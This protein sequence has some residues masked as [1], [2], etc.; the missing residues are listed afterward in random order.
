MGEML[1]TVSVNPMSTV[2][3]SHQA[4][5]RDIFARYL[6]YGRNAHVTRWAR[7]NHAVRFW[8]GQSAVKRVPL[9][10]LEVPHRHGKLVDSLLQSPGPEEC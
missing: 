8:R 5:H 7:R 1:V 10:L 3:T 6:E 9:P 2:R 4:N